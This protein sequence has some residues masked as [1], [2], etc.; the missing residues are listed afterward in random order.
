MRE[1][2][3]EKELE[4]TEEVYDGLIQ[5][6]RSLGTMLAET[7][8]RGK[9]LEEFKRLRRDLPQLIWQADLRMT[10]LRHELLERRARRAEDEYRRAAE[11]VSKAARAL[12]QARRAYVKA[13]QTAKRLGPE[14]RQ[15]AEQRDKEAKHL[16]ELLRIPED[17]QRY[18][19]EHQRGE[20]GGKRAEMRE[21]GHVAQEQRQ[22]GEERT[23]DPRQVHAGDVRATSGAH[24]VGEDADRRSADVTT[25]DIISLIAMGVC[26]V[27][28]A[29]FVLAYLLAT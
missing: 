20:Q 29:A 13:E 6:R 7:I 16:Q 23:Q 26:A 2:Q 22:Q 4:Q 10:E 15:L 21:G 3:L 14:A 18:Q 19:G 8:R 28:L 24:T 5:T 9:D 17:A 11:E 27:A 12:E 1:S 25:D